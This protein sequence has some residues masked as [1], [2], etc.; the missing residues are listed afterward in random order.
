M[1]KQCL[2]IKARGWC[3][4]VFLVVSETPQQNGVAERFNRTMVEIGR[5]LLNQAKL[6]KKYWV[7]AL[8]IAVHIRNLTVSA[9]SN[10]G[11]SPFELF[12]GKTPTIIDKTHADSLA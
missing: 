12:T 3:R 10:Q 11:K 6:S 9:N 1:L 4:H 7:R 2:E 5:R 8:A